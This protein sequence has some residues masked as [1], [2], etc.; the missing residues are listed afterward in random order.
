MLK[1]LDDKTK[2]DLTDLIVAL[3]DPE[4]FT[5]VQRRW[6]KRDRK[7]KMKIEFWKDFGFYTHWR[8]MPP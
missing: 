3:N 5:K 8:L 4:M 6:K 7:R 1:D 2:A